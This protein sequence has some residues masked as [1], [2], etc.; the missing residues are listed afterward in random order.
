MRLRSAGNPARLPR[1]CR[2]K[3]PGLPHLVGQD[4]VYEPVGGEVDGSCAGDLDAVGDR[5]YVVT[6]VDGLGRESAFSRPAWV[7]QL[8]SPDAVAILPGGDRIVLDGRNGTDL[9][10]Q[11]LRRQLSSAAGQPSRPPG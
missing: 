2:H 9:L 1:R 8:V 7:P 11:G 4:Q 10:R 6:A 3:P 5:T